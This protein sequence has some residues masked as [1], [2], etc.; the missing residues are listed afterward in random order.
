MLKTITEW[1]TICLVI[2][3]VAPLPLLFQNLNAQYSITSTLIGRIPVFPK[4][5]PPNYYSPSNSIIRISEK[6]FDKY[7]AIR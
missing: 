5:V 3:M 1:L 4:T 2:L 6:I 7:G